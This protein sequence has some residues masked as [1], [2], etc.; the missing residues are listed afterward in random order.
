MITKQEILHK[1][2]NLNLLPSTV[3]KDYVLGWVL[4]SLHTHSKVSKSWVFKG[5]TCLKKCYFHEYRYS[6]DLDFTLIK[7]EEELEQILK[8]VTKWVYQESGIEL[9]EK[10]ISLKTYTNPRGFPSTQCKLTYFGPLGQKTNFP[11][12]KIDLTTDEKIALPIEKRT[13]FHPYS[14]KP[15]TPY[16]IPSY[17]YEE[18]FAEKIRALAERARPRDLYDVIHLYQERKW[19]SKKSNLLT[20]LKA[21]CEFKQIA[22]PKLSDINNHPNRKALPSQ[23]KNMLGHQ[24]P[25]LK[26]FD[27]YWKELKNAL[28]WLYM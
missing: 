10:H 25:I 26:D 16:R 19:L 6:E 15:S 8:E 3:E 27:E 22:M 24:L 5:G 13:I 2:R 14:D 17:C 1:A 12:I 20:A 23:W 28:D 9:P 18:I 7:E 11:R 21:K 4:M